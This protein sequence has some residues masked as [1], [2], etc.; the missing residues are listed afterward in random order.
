[1]KTDRLNTTE[2]FK[3]KIFIVLATLL[4]MTISLYH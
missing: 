4:C 1:M 3:Y 2:I